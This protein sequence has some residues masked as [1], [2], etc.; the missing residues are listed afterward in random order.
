MVLVAA[1]AVTQSYAQHMHRRSQ[2]KSMQLLVH[3]T[4]SPVSPSQLQHKQLPLVA[5]LVGFFGANS[6]QVIRRLL[7]GADHRLRPQR[8]CIVLVLLATL[9]HI[10]EELQ[11]IK[12]PRYSLAHSPLQ[13]CPSRRSLCPCQLPGPA[14]RELHR[15]RCCCHTQFRSSATLTSPFRRNPRDSAL[16]LQESIYIHEQRALRVLQRRIPHRQLYA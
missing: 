5:P 16:C 4:G 15:C 14:P 9:V 10:E 8:V 3:T 7:I 11:E 1:N 13:E 2:S 6:R 12:T